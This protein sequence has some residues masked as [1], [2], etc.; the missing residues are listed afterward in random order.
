[1]QTLH[2]S[3]RRDLNA[4]P[5]GCTSTLISAPTFLSVDRLPCVFLTSVNTVRKITILFSRF[6]LFCFGFFASCPCGG[7]CLVSAAPGPGSESGPTLSANYLKLLS[8]LASDPKN[9]TDILIE[10]V[11]GMRRRQIWSANTHQGW[12]LAA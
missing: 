5:C 12:D 6:G 4:G 8:I 1:M 11:P 7:H 2:Q 10:A 9:W 3:P